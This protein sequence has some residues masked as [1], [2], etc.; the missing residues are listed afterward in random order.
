MR[1]KYFHVI[2]VMLCYMKIIGRAMLCVYIATHCL[3]KP[4]YVLGCSMTPTLKEGTLALSNIIDRHI[5]K[6]ERFDI[7]VLRHEDEVLIKRLIALPKE[8]ISYHNDQLYI[9]GFPIEENF[10]DPVYI[11]KQKKQWKIPLFT[12][13]FKEYTLKKNEY[14][15]MGDNRLDSYDSRAFGGVHHSDILSKDILLQL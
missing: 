7:V 5:S 1:R 2:E 3:L 15:V 11:E 4:I 14:F 8:T 10:L 12:Q 6:L 13:D 9:D